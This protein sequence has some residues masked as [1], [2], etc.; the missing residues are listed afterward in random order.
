[1]LA[2]SVLKFLISIGLVGYFVH[3]KESF[4][5]PYC[6]TWQNVA[7]ILVEQPVN[8]MTNELHKSRFSIQK[9]SGTN[10]LHSFISNQTV[11]FPT[12]MIHDKTFY[13]TYLSK[14]LSSTAELILYF[15]LNAIPVNKP[16]NGAD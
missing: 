9:K 4:P 16:K 15:L 10:K 7:N 12:Q 13:S 6:I 5:S 14:I 2:D 1:M 3:K 8:T 11:S